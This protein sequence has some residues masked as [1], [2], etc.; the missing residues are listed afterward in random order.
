MGFT[1]FHFSW[2]ED[3]LPETYDM[4][5]AHADMMAYHFDEGVPWPEAYA[6]KPFHENVEAE[7]TH[8]KEQLRP[9]KKL[10]VATTPINFERKGVADYWEEKEQVKRPKDWKDVKLDDPRVIEAYINYCVR[11]IEKFDPDYFVYGVEV[12]LLA[13]NNPEEYK[14]FQ[15]LASKVYPAL[16]KRYPKMPVALSFYLHAPN[17]MKETRDL[18]KPLLPYTDLYAVS[19]YPYMG[20]EADGYAAKDIPSNWWTQTREIAPGK[21]FAIAENGFI[22]EDLKVLN[23]KMPGSDE[24]QRL[25][26]ERM[27]RDAAELDAQFVVWFVVADYDELWGVLKWMVLF[28]PL[29]RAWKDTGLYDGELEPR[30]AL[31]VWDQWLAKP[32]SQ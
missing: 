15:T 9:G 4:I 1:P 14:R 23:K 20:Y 29:I 24:A 18:V 2:V 31:Q 30:P 19:S 7:L 10:Y 25:Y 12:N 22:A 32:V 6:N 13:L 3:R 16:K 21:P 27:L 5:Y 28:N 11:L 26:T 17:R 8:R